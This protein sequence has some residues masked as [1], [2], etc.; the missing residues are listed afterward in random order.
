MTGRSYG[1][2]D[3]DAA[4]SVWGG[5]LLI[6]LT[7]VVLGVG[8][9]WLGLRNETWGLSWIAEDRAEIPELDGLVTAPP[10]PGDGS[11]VPYVDSDDPMAIP[12]AAASAPGLP[13]IPEL[14]RPI[15]VQL[16]AA[17]R[18]FDAG[19]LLFVDAREPEE[20][21]AGHIAGA[22]NLPADATVTDPALLESLDSGGRVLVTYCGGGTCE[23][24]LTLAWSLVN[25]GHP[26]VL[27]FMGGYPEW[28]GAG[29]PVETGEAQ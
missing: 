16:E 2:R 21:A 24:S 15:Q 25:A 20:Y 26:K 6:A 5:I 28:E 9:N 7:G 23:Q 14:G 18:F 29:Y 19:A 11:S 4:G 22:V 3:G 10:A 27:V 17:K 13:E 1:D 8:Y 12:D